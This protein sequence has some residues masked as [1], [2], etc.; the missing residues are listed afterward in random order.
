METR[1]DITTSLRDIVTATGIDL[2]DITEITF[3]AR[4]VMLVRHVI[5]DAGQIQV[6]GDEILTAVLEVPI[7]WTYSAVAK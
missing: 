3:S 4:R 1:I 6:D 5:R 7:T 2:D